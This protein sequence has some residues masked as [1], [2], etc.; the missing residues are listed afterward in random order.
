MRQIEKQNFIMYVLCCMAKEE[1]SFFAL[2]TAY[3][4]DNAV[5][6]GP[7]DY[8]PYRYKWVKVNFN[9]P[10]GKLGPISDSIWKTPI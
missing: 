3:E 4:K 5:T 6:N 8:G 1:Q 10:Y 7:K 2:L 9:S